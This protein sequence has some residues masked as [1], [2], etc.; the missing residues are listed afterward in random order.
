MAISIFLPTDDRK[1][2]INQLIFTLPK[3]TAEVDQNWIIP[4]GPGAAEAPSSMIYASNSGEKNRR[5]I[6]QM[7]LSP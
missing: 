3:V 1:V 2:W 7:K 6:N 5:K 4:I